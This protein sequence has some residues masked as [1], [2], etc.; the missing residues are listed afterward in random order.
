MTGSPPIIPFR[1]TR[2]LSRRQ[3]DGKM[4]KVLYQQL[5]SLSHWKRW[6]VRHTGVARHSG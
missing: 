5:A 6:Q 2:L 1:F 3:A 4:S